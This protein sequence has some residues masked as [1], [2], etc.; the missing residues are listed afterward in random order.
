[1]GKMQLEMLDFY[2]FR[3]WVLG[4]RFGLAKMTARIEDV[5]GVSHA[6]TVEATE[7]VGA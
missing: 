2:D 6:M 5:V 3:V 1:M 7:V 4:E